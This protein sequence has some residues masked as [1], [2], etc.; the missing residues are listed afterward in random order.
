MRSQKQLMDVLTPWAKEQLARGHSIDEVL[1][2]LRDR[3]VRAV[4]S[5][6]I[7]THATDMPSREAKRAVF[8]SPVWDD[9]RDS[10]VKAQTPVSEAAGLPTNK[11][12][13]SQE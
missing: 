13:G 8:V 9:I 10:W 11:R 1:Q 7:L 2:G 4:P 12:G 3:G 5:I 6:W